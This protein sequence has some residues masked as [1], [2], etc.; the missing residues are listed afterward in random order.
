MP[1]G[2]T[3]DETYPPTPSFPVT[4]EI[5]CNV[6]RAN[7][8]IVVC[9]RTLT[10]SNGHSAMSAKNSADA[11][12]ARYSHVRQRIAFSSPTRSLYHH[13]KNS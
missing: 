8:G 7:G 1:G 13:L 6:P 12:A 2:R 11:L 4:I 3:G 9:I 10:A 5:P